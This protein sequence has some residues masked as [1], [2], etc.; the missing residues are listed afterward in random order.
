MVVI[1]YKVIR[2]FSD[3]HPDAEEALDNWYRFAEEADWSNFNELRSMFG[4]V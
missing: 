1:S 4:G 3:E 2:E